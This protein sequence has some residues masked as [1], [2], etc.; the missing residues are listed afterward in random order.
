[1]SNSIDDLHREVSGLRSDLNRA[2]QRKRDRESA[3]RWAVAGAVGMKLFLDA[4]ERREESRRVAEAIEQQKRADYFNTW[5]NNDPAGARYRQWEPGARQLVARTNARD[6]AWF[7]QWNAVLPYFR[8]QV[9]QDEQERLRRWPARLH[10]GGLKTAAIVAFVAAAVAALWFVA[11]FFTAPPL[12]TFHEE[13][14]IKTYNYDMTYE[15]CLEAAEIP[16]IDFVTSPAQCEAANPIRRLAVRGGT[17]VGLLVVG[18]G[19]LMLRKSAIKKAEGD[20]R[21]LEEAEARVARFGYD[22]LLVGPG[23][24]PFY[25]AEEPGFIERVDA[26]NE[27][28]ASRFSQPTNLPPTHS[29]RIANQ[30]Y[31]Y[32]A[33]VNVLLATFEA[34][35]S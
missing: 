21:V 3:A 29:P 13:E 17:T 23:E 6:S 28:I 33:E 27:T 24:A 20:T 5:L 25:W 8:D 15:Q 31:R 14:G 19:L 34:Q 12:V 16:E 9:P 30:D 1:M 35:N 18:A 22:P 10:Q 32:P 4:Q 11:S 26:V 7:G 2:E